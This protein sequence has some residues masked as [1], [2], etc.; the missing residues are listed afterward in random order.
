VALALRAQGYSVFGTSR[1]P[2]EG[3]GDAEPPLL[4][5]DVQSEES[6]A[7]VIADVLRRAGRLDVV[8]NN[9][10]YRFHGAVEETSVDEARALFET[11]FLGMHRVTRAVLPILREGGRG[12]I[13]NI[14]SLAGLNAP[15]FGGLYAASKAA[16]EAYSEALWHEVRRLG[17]HVSVIEP[18]PMRSTGRV[19]PQ[20]PRQTI[21]AYDGPRE[22]AL[23]AV[24]QAE[25]TER[26]L[27]D[28]VAACVVRVVG[29]R[30]PQLRYRVG[31]QATWLPLLKAALPWAWY[32]K[33]VQ[34]KYDLEG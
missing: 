24:R 33:G 31:A 6:V 18:G 10:A 14:S 16:V 27:P 28:R 19:L 32:A 5:L 29:S 23:A 25:Q 3:A 9:A 13:V 22:R 11:N 15:P 12:R 26:L 30:S 7:G 8:V 4:P 1:R 20:Q 21:A 34:R 17:I 2:V